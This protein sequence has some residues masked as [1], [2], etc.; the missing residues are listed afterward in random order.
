[1]TVP[2]IILGTLA[3]FAGFLNAGVLHFTPMEHW[4]EPVFA[5]ATKGAVKVTALAE[6]LEHDW[7]K[8]KMELLLAVPAFLA[9]AGG[10][11]LA[12]SW[13]VVQKGAPAKALAEA[14]PGLYKGALNKWYVDEIYD[15][16]ALAAVDAL[17][18]TAAS[19]D[20]SIV[21]GIIAR[22]TAL[23]VAAL[24]TVLRVFQNGVVH[25]YAAMMVVGLAAVGAFFALPHADA[26]VTEK[27]GDYVI[28]AGPGLGY[29]FRWDAD[30][31]GKPDKE[32]YTAEQTRTVHL[33]PGSSKTVALEVKNAFGLGAKKLI[34]VSRPAPP[35]KPLELGQ[36]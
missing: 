7:G 16:T 8:S 5:S 34:N 26:T 22:L 14:R 4:L 10:G 35:A 19:V 24:G 23:V 21:D 3:V 11:Y 12:Y 30:G 9:F 27:N 32:A 15:R 25:V 33:E 31:D 1:M 29:Q 2:L 13:Y 6:H 17:G 20:Q 36:N 28:E 18:D